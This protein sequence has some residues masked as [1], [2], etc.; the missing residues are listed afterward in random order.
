[1][2]TLH[3]F[4]RAVETQVRLPAAHRNVM[5]ADEEQ[6]VNANPTRSYPPLWVS[7]LFYRTVLVLLQQDVSVTTTA[8]DCE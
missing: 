5:E 2:A 1:M 7:T 4:A 6:V 8:P 3:L